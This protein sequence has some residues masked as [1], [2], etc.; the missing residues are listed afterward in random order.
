M[1]STHKGSF[2]GLVRFRSAGGEEL[3]LDDLVNRACEAVSRAVA[4]SPITFVSCLFRGEDHLN[5][6]VMG[7]EPVP[8]GK[9]YA[10][11]I[12]LALRVGH[13]HYDEHVEVVVDSP[14]PPGSGAPPVA[15]TVYDVVPCSEPRAPRPERVPDA[16]R[17]GCN[18]GVGY[19]D[20]DDARVDDWRR[21]GGDAV[22]VFGARDQPGVCYRRAE[23]YRAWQN[24]NHESYVG[25]YTGPAG[26]AEVHHGEPHDEGEAFHGRRSSHPYHMVF[27]MFNT[28]HWVL[29][30]WRSLARRPHARAFFLRPVGEFYLGSQVH[31]RSSMHGAEKH[32]VYELA[33]VEGAAGGG[34]AAAEG[35]PAPL[36]NFGLSQDWPDKIVD[37]QAGETHDPPADSLS[38]DG[39]VYVSP[40][41]KRFVENA[42]AVLDLAGAQE[43]RGALTA[44]LYESYVRHSLLPDGVPS[45]YLDILAA[46]LRAVGLGEYLSVFAYCPEVGVCPALATAS[47]ARCP[48]DGAGGLGVPYHVPDKPVT[49]P[50]FKAVRDQYGYVTLPPAEVISEHNYAVRDQR[51]M[52]LA[53]RMIGA[54]SYYVRALV[55]PKH[56]PSPADEIEFLRGV[57]GA[58]GY[59]P[60]EAAAMLRTNS[61]KIMIVFLGRR[62]RA[63]QRATS[64]I[65]SLDELARVAFGDLAGEPLKFRS[66][67]ARQAYRSGLAEQA[68]C[69]LS[70]LFMVHVLQRPR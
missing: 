1:G 64:G 17:L 55:D 66:D 51:Q 15:A 35:V 7:G 13:N 65:G 31:S 49:R 59:T 18:P 44:E 23:L 53:R 69:P 5:V 70:Y 40:R 46:E 6:T 45:H 14:A 42:R 54:D 60:A 33:P 28:G 32:A 47:R 41:A 10:A 52:L 67:A 56:A 58:C 3:G 12:D 38:S 20:G 24:G 11:L 27:R 57:F 8:R 30:A 39:A 16:E 25:L 26:G 68:E 4:V 48:R 50:L 63:M 29:D 62:A 2:D 21:E 36:P 61:E 9:L 34:D 22:V 37:V 43:A 19:M